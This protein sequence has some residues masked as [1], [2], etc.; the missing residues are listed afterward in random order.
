[1]PEKNRRI[2]TT[3]ANWYTQHDPFACCFFGA[4][5]AIWNRILEFVGVFTWFW[6]A[7]NASKMLKDGGETDRRFNR[8]G[9]TVVSNYL[10]K[11]TQKSTGKNTS[12]TSPIQTSKML[13]C[14][15]T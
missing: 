2:H 7:K 4:F 9:I 3:R 13:Y 5:I 14:Q 6:A 10:G 1:M 8:S 11:N 15:A 12:H